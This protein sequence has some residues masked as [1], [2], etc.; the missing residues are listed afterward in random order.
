MPTPSPATAIVDGAAHTD[1]STGTFFQLSLET[2]KLVAVPGLTG[3]PKPGE[4]MVDG[5]MQLQM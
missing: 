5:M 4:V 2:G 3:S 1:D